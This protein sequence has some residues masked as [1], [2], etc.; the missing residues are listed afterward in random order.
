MQA[1]SRLGREAAGTDGLILALHDIGPDAAP[2]VGHKAFRL[3]RLIQAGYRVPSGFCITARSGTR[4]SA[5]QAEAIVSAWRAAGYRAAAIRS[6]ATEE[7]GHEASWAG[8]FPTVLPVLDERGLLAAV[9]HCLGALHGPEAIRY[10]GTAGRASRLPGMAVLVHELVEA[11][12]AGILF[13]A[14]P[15]TGAADEMVVNAVP[16]LGEPLAAGRVTG[17]S[18]V[19]ARDG[20]VKT[21]TVSP[22]PAMLTVRGEVAIDGG[23]RDRPVLTPPQLTRLSRL[24][25]GIERMFGCP[26]DIEFA[27]SGDDIQIL[28][29]RPITGMARQDAAAELDAY[30]AAERDRLRRRVDDLRRQGRLVGHDAVFSNGNIGELLPTPTPMSFALF[31][32]IFSGVEGAIVRGRRG[33]G[34]RLADD[35]AVGLFELVCGQPRFNVEVDAGTFDIGLPLAVDELLAE[36]AAD[37]DRANYPEFGLYRQDLSLAEAEAR[38]GREEGQRLHA[39]LRGFRRA[40][41]A[42]AGTLLAEFAVMREPLLR[43]DLAAARSM[44]AAA[45]HLPTAELI[46]A[47]HAAIGRLKRESCTVFVTVARLGFFFAD[48]V[49]GGLARHLGD[50]GLAAPVLQGLDGSRITEQALDL[51]RLAAGQIGRADFLAAYGHMAVNE[52]EVALPRLTET[53]E[54]VD[55]LLAE[56]AR[57]GRRP[58][59]DFRRLRRTRLE[60]EAD[61][62]RRLAAAGVAEDEVA[63]L[64]ADLALA[65]ALLPLRETVKYYFAADYAALRAILRTL[66]RRLGWAEDDI[67][68]LHPAEVTAAAFASA[69]AI[70]ETI[71]GRRRERRLAEMLARQRRVPAVVFA[72]RLDALGA[73]PESRPLSRLNGTPVAP[74]TAVGKARLLDD[75]GLKAGCEGVRGDEIIVA[76]SANLG[77]APTLRVAAGL[78]VE[79]GGVLAHAA[80]QARESGI[81]AVVLANATA[82][83]RDGMTIRIDGHTGL[84]EPLE[85]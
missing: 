80:C 60:A 4:L 57:S 2:L 28:Q 30:V 37:P 35:A 19:L 45:E 64:F 49:R 75:H 8:V 33:L 39:R 69:P 56:L 43:R 26:Q 68:H 59:A 48:L 51:G 73:W 54:T 74:G 38:H 40:M 42:K 71:A 85:G 83:L 29:A 47:F 11:D 55:R 79:V 76:R 72:S 25:E 70:A 17:D 18:F 53:P 58:V 6:S 5:A 44:V 23:R 22:K 31:Q 63:D 32:E 21:A 65:Q 61:L 3:G 20:R 7:D 34:Y 9:E 27:V 15:V 62:R 81:P 82:V 12:V 41:A 52:L 50:G 14:N 66:N 10:R 78:V 67:F 24:A 84:V 77:L 16:G 36:V 13:T 46:G 1:M